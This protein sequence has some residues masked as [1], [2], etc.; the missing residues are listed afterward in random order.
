MSRS[1][2][3]RALLSLAAS[4]LPALAS[5]EPLDDALRRCAKEHDQ[6][7]R[8]ACFDTLASGLPQIEADRFGMKSVEES[9]YW[10][11]TANSCDSQD[12]A[13]WGNDGPSVEESP[14]FIVGFP[15]SGTTLL[16][17]VLDAHPRLQSMPRSSTLLP[18]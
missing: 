8:L 12:V 9:A 17:Q 6:T 5:A 4:C 13:A 11:L 10:T 1:I 15:R 18:G 7:Q 3:R 16:E 14:V 2:A